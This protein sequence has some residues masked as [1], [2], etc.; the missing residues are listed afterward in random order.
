[1]KIYEEK[2]SE[3][4]SNFFVTDD[5][6]RILFFDERRFYLNSINEILDWINNEYSFIRRAHVA[7]SKNDIF[8][9]GFER[10][11]VIHDLAEYLI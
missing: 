5:E 9:A 10:E 8:I 2:Y 1:M 3:T 6:D 7:I 4:H 11:T